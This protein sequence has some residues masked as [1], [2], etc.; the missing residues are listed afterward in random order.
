MKAGIVMVLLAGLSASASATP[1]SMF[2][3]SLRTLVDADGQV[4]DAVIVGNVPDV[5]G[6]AAA[7]YL[8]TMRFLPVQRDGQAVSGMT[9]V[10]LRGCAL[11]QEDGKLKLAFRHRDN[12]PLVDA[13]VPLPSTR[14]LVREALDSGQSSINWSMLI[15]VN[16]DGSAVLEQVEGGPR[17][18]TSRMA[19][20]TLETIVAG[21][22]FMP[23][24]VDGTPVAT[25]MQMPVILGM[26]QSPRQS[27][28][29]AQ[30]AITS[31]AACLALERD[32]TMVPVAVDSVFR[33]LPPA[34]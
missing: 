23:E 6:Q 12:G 8:R 15:R 28:R 5:I 26:E 27:R 21:M 13:T 34:G 3:V 20:Q 24:Q 10:S 32:A 4:S 7:D 31:E 30:A 16:E 22:R 1:P 25:R 18:G 11:P 9:Y 17:R 33:L 2:N 19:R 29:D 14:G